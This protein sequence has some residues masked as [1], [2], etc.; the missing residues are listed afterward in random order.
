M[1]KSVT[2]GWGGMDG[3]DWGVMGR[4]A[5]KAKSFPTYSL[6]FGFWF[7]VL[8]LGLGLGFLF[9]GFLGLFC[10]K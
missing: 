8:V 10:R 2:V 7:L 9:F 4:I 1:N 6:G 5:A 3:P